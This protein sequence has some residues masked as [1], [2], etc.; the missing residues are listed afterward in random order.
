MDD[1]SNELTS[2]IFSVIGTEFMLNKGEKTYSFYS[3]INLIRKNYL[4]NKN[5]MRYFIHKI[6]DITEYSDVYLEDK[7]KEGM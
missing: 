5:K 1:L 7:K 3:K 6:R 4:R 2:S